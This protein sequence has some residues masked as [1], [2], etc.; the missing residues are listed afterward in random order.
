MMFPRTISL[1][2][3]LLTSAAFSQDI[4]QELDRADHIGRGASALI[5]RDEVQPYWPENGSKLVYRVDTGRDEHRF[6]Q[7]DLTT[8]AKAP[9]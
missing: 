1:L 4:R 5:L 9:A 8:G 2:T 6:Y 3:T 7:V